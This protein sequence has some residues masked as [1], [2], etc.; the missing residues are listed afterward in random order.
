M[1]VVLR[2]GTGDDAGVMVLAMLCEEMEEDGESC[3]AD[4][5]D[6]GGFDDEAG[7]ESDGVV[8]LPA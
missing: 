8:R 1:L 5:A 7:A 2:E 6:D 3:G 4:G